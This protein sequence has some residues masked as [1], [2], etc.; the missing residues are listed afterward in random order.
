MAEDVWYGPINQDRKLSEAAMKSPYIVT[1]QSGCPEGLSLLRLLGER[2]GPVDLAL[3][4]DL[5]HIAN[6]EEF[7][8]A[9][10]PQDHSTLGD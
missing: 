6:R 5:R 4:S 7:P 3:Y 2:A 9:T 8:W 10:R 1:A